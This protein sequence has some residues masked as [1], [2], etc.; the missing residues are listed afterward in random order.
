MPTLEQLIKENRLKVL[1]AVYKLW[2]GQKYIIVKGKTIGGS[3]FLIERG[4]SWFNKKMDNNGILY[5]HFY[6][7]IKSKPSLSFELEI[8]L[9]SADALCIL[10]KEQDELDKARYDRY[11]LNN[12]IEA[13]LPQYNEA[14]GMYGWIEKSAILSF[15]KYLKSKCR[16]RLLSTYRPKKRQVPA[17]H[18]S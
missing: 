10:K 1:P 6:S 11:C 16:A 8:I 7:Y 4:F 12:Q 14:T 18:V 13:Y 3:L 9:K 17:K 5:R 15:Q 2:Y